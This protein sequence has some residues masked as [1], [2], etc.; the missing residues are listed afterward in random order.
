VCDGSSGYRAFSWLA[1]AS[2][3][4]ALYRSGMIH[5]VSPVRPE[6]HRG[7]VF[8]AV[9]YTADAHSFDD[10]CAVA[11]GADIVHLAVVAGRHSA[12]VASPSRLVTAPNNPRPYALAV[13]SDQDTA[14]KC[15]GDSWRTPA[16]YWAEGLTACQRLRRVRTSAP[17]GT[18]TGRLMMLGTVEPPTA[19]QHNQ[20]NVNAVASLSR[21]GVNATMRLLGFR[22]GKLRTV[23]AAAG[24]P[25]RTNQPQGGRHLAS[26]FVLLVRRFA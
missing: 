15:S 12:T 7:K 20:G 5:F 17:S 1:L 26:L 9:G 18:N 2:H 16:S 24:G 8:F 6:N 3:R 4:Y 21:A 25:A 11:H 10:G 22:I 14:P 19:G 13:C 23:A